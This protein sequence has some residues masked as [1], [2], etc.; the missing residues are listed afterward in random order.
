MEPTVP[1]LPVYVRSPVS[2]PGGNTT[3]TADLFKELRT[4]T[5]N[6]PLA[7]DV[8]GTFEATYQALESADMRQAAA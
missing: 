7:D 1:N 6:Y 8:C 5:R 4:V 2:S 3:R